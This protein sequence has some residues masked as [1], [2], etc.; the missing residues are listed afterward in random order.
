MN[1]VNSDKWLEIVKDELTSMVHNKVWGLV[2]LLEGRQKVGCKWII[3]TKRD[4]DGNLE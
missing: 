2:E 1:D 4:S 3:K